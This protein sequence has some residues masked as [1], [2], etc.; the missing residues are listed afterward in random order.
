MEK[1]RGTDREAVLIMLSIKHHL[2]PKKDKGL[3][4]HFW[5]D[6][7]QVTAEAAAPS[8]LFFHPAAFTSLKTSW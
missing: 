1:V 4:P 5:R 3:H 8:F 2:F 7:H 6:R